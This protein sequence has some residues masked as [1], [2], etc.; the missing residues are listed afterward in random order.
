MTPGSDAPAPGGEPLALDTL[1][2]DVLLPQI[3]AF[4]DA[5]ADPAAR[6]V[7]LTLKAAVE[8]GEIAPVELQARLGA[9][10]E[11]ALQSGRIRRLF[12]P[13]AELSLNAL[14]Q[15]TPRGR[16]IATSLRELNRALAK[17]KGDA[18]EELTAALRAPGAY[19]LTLKTSGCQLTIRFEPSGVRLESAEL[20]LD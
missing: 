1:Q 15:K 3:Q 13:G 12:G 10:V 7:Y 19:A 4:I 8:A 18:V 16:E 11:V 20:A 5:T 2:R 17:L 9:I 14:F 6:E